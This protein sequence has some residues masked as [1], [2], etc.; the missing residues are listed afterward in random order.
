M[1]RGTSI[2][3]VMNSAFDPVHLQS[4]AAGI[5]GACAADIDQS[6]KAQRAPHHRQV[7]QG[8]AMH[9]WSWDEFQLSY[10]APLQLFSYQDRGFIWAAQNFESWHV[11]AKPVVGGLAVGKHW[12]NTSTIRLLISDRLIATIVTDASL[13]K[14]V[15]GN[16]SS[17]LRLI[18]LHTAAIPAIKHS[19]ARKPCN[20]TFATYLPMFYKRETFRNNS[21]ALPYSMRNHRFIF[22]DWNCGVC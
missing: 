12:C 8:D 11:F 19:L 15:W 5:G 4:L 18:Y 22:E 16:I 10:G 9:I 17:L 1:S 20:S 14:K 3:N 2:C 13:A 6:N 7:I 21:Y